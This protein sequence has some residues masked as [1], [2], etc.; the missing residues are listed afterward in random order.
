M[1]NQPLSSFDY[2]QSCS[3]SVS[4]LSYFSLISPGQSLYECE[5][6]FLS[7]VPVGGVLFHVITTVWELLFYFFIYYMWSPLCNLY[8]PSHLLQDTCCPYFCH[9][10]KSLI[11]F[12]IW[13]IRYAIEPPSFLYSVPIT[14]LFP[15]Q[16]QV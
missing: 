5:F 6:C 12:Q 16:F 4:S 3:E 10:S 8:L 14:H 13:G 9:T 11:E 15:H 7:T 2:H 1:P